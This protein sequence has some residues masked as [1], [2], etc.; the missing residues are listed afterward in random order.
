MAPI[1][2]FLVGGAVV[3]VLVAT[4]AGCGDE[5]PRGRTS[6]AEPT[7]PDPWVDIDTRYPSEDLAATTH[8]Y[9]QAMAAGERQRACRF[10]YRGS[11]DAQTQEAPC[12]LAQEMPP[13]DR[14]FTSQDWERFAAE[15]ADSYTPEEDDRGWTVS[16]ATTPVTTWRLVQDDAGIWHID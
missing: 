10:Q 3:T 6:G 5:E 4:T 2:R 13:R 11:S 15:G 1:R 8:G 14:R 16:L 12:R 7:P 9:V